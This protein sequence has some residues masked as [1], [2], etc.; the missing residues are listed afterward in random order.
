VTNIILLFTGYN[1]KSE[2]IFNSEQ[3]LTLTELETGHYIENSLRDIM[4]C[5]HSVVRLVIDVALPYK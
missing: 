5:N 3:T 2:K 1:S 4:L